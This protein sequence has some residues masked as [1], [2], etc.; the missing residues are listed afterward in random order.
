M[1]EA[2]GRRVA[3][4]MGL[5]MA[6]SVGILIRAH[7]S[8]WLT[9]E[10]TEEAFEIIRGSTRRISEALLRSALEAIRDVS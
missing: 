8:G 4:N 2:A 7:R 6:G 5:P 1:D 3:K 9:R 10:E